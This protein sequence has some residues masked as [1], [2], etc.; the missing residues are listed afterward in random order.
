MQICAERDHVER[1]K[2]REKMTRTVRKLQRSN[3]LP[4]SS[5]HAR[6]SIKRQRKSSATV[7]QTKDNPDRD[8][9]RKSFEE[10]VFDE[11]HILKERY[12]KALAR[13][14]WVQCFKR[15]SGH[16]E[17]SKQ[18][19]EIT[20][21]IGKVPHIADL[22]NLFEEKNFPFI[23]YKEFSRAEWF[24]A[25]ILCED[26]KIKEEFAKELSSLEWVE[27]FKIVFADQ[28]RQNRNLEIVCKFGMVPRIPDILKLFGEEI[29]PFIT[30]KEFAK[31]EWFETNILD[32]ELKMKKE[33]ANDLL[34][35]SWVKKFH[36]GFDGKKD[37][38]WKIYITHDERKTP[39]MEELEK[40]FGDKI[41]Y[42]VD[43]IQER[44][45]SDSYSGFLRGPRPGDAVYVSNEPFGGTITILGKDIYMQKHYAITC[46]H[47]CFNGKLKE[48]DLF[49]SHK[50]MKREHENG[51]GNLAGVRYEYSDENG[52]RVLGTFYRGLYNDEHDIALIQLDECWGC[53]DA[54][55]YLEREGVRENL[56]SK[57]EVIENLKKMGGLAR[58]V[59]F[60]SVSKDR[61]GELFAID[62]RPLK[63]GLNSGFYGIRS[64]PGK[65]FFSEP[66]D[67][68]SLVCMKC[69]DGRKVPFAYLSNTRLFITVL[70]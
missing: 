13:L 28:G 38:T 53:H 37:K 56:A 24:E 60:G 70:I 20:C 30:Y 1:G 35:L 68:G 44:V 40:I 57:R 8:L 58:V 29:L 10:K 45:V 50:E 12:G 67:S 39:S 21:K 36:I 66:G 64:L 22:E 3:S 47:V 26:F 11:N 43:F 15:V 69:K 23:T 33:Y 34:R 65:T 27:C 51:S 5:F 6:R 17:C 61:E 54:V 41:F 25:N 9:K 2:M 42:F 48:F 16:G 31:T 63:N 62:A 18:V 4:P 32:E 49:E 59:K 52:R 46:Y 7:R 55:N 14:E 19:L